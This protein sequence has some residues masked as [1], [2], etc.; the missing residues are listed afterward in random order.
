MAETATTAGHATPAKAA[1]G[2]PLTQVL[3]AFSDGATGLDDIARRTG[4]SAQVVRASV[5]HLVRIGRI[6]AR[7]LTVGCPSGGCGGCASA[8]ADG[9]AGCGA[10]GPSATRTGP[11]LVALRLRRPADPPG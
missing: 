7:S 6:E 2:G 3:A 8:S 4:L 1:G 11:T 9:A 10:S 5:D